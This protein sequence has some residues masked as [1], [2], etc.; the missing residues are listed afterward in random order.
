[1]SKPNNPNN[2][3]NINKPNNMDKRNKPLLKTPTVWEAL[4]TTIKMASVS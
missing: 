2:T 4:M 1:M 3:D